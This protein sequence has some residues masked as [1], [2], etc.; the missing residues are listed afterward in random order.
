MKSGFLLLFCLGACGLLCFIALLARLCGFI[1]FVSSHV[2]IVFF[3]FV[4]FS[5]LRIIF[6]GSVCFGVEIFVRFLFLL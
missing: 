1:L 2:R 3:G 5:H 6:F 4:W